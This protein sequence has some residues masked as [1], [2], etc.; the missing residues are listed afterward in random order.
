[1]ASPSGFFRTTL[2]LLSRDREGAVLTFWMRQ[3]N[4]NSL[5]A[6]VRFS[7]VAVAWTL[8]LNPHL[9]NRRM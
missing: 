1:M 4:H 7:Q 2:A 6:T 8:T 3:A 9:E 5:S